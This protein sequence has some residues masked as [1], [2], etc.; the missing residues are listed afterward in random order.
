MAS[1]KVFVCFYFFFNHK[2]VTRCYFFSSRPPGLC[3]FLLSMW[4]NGSKVAVKALKQ[5]GSASALLNSFN[6]PDWLTDWLTTHPHE[7]MPFL[8]KRG[9]ASEWRNLY[10]ACAFR[11]NNNIFHNLNNIAC[12]F[13]SVKWSYPF[14]LP[15]DIWWF[16]TASIKFLNISSNSGFILLFRWNALQKVRVRNCL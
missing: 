2:K 16:S 15:S 11:Q 13:F 5:T 9:T 8:V 14:L 7:V 1:R 10:K 6:R 4:Q 3:V 12:F